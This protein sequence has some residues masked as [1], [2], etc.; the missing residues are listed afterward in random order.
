M[1]EFENTFDRYEVD[2]YD[3]FTNECIQIVQNKI[4][5]INK[6]LYQM[7]EDVEKLI[8]GCHMRSVDRF[9]NGDITWTEEAIDLE[10]SVIM[11][12]I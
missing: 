4:C 7:E 2:E 3:V 8:H 9:I 1:D 5:E 6:S 12:G 11:R 10:N